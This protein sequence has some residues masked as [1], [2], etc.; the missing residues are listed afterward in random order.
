MNKRSNMF[1]NLYKR[2]QIYE[3]FL[4]QAAFI[5]RPDL[6]QVVQT[7][8]RFTWPWCKARTLCRLG[9][10]R[11]LVTL[12]AWLTL[13]PTCG[14]LPQIWH[15]LDMIVISSMLFG[16]RRRQTAAASGAGPA[17]L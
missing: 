10:K 6:I 16:M 8:M 14:F 13:F 11:R 3:K 15:I 12:W 1:Y 2:I 4:P 5:T 7:S 17:G 9:L